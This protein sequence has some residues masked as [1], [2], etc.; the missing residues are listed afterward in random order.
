[1][2]IGK[3]KTALFVDGVEVASTT[4]ITIKPSDVH[5]VL[6]YLGRS[7][8]LADPYFTGQIDDVQIYNYALD[9]EGVQQTMTGVASGIALPAADAANGS[10]IYGLDGRSYPMLRRGLNIVDGRKVIK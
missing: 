3:N 5:P 6:N 2:S 8:F 10:N 4:D 7:Q 1:V 9:A